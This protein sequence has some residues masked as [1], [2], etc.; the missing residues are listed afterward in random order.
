MNNKEK[1]KQNLKRLREIYENNPEISGILD[2][3]DVEEYNEVSNAWKIFSNPRIMNTINPENYVDILGSIIKEDTH[4]YKNICTLVKEVYGE[5]ARQIIQERPELSMDD[6][7]NFDIF[8][9]QIR[10]TIGYGG[11]HTFL[12]YYMSSEHIITEL[13]Q[14]P[15]LITY[16]KEFEKLTEGF[17][18]PS[19]IGLEDRLLAFEKHRG[20]IKS[21]VDS[22]KQNEYTN[23]LL[24]LLRD[25]EGFSM[26]TNISVAPD[27][28]LFDPQTDLRVDTLEQL[29]DYRRKREDVLQTYIEEVSD[30]P[31]AH[32][33]VVPIVLFK[34]FGIVKNSPGQYNAYD[35]K[36]FL[37]DYLQFNKTELTEDEIDLIEIYSILEEIEDLELLRKI[38]SFLS[39]R[40]DVVTPLRMK[41]IDNKVVENY[42]SEYVDSLVK[43]EQ[44]RQMAEDPES[45][46]YRYICKKNGDICYP[47]HM[48]CSSDNSQKYKNYIVRDG[49]KVYEYVGKNGEKITKREEKDTTVY[50][51]ENMLMVPSDGTSLYR[52]SL[53]ITMKNGELEEYFWPTH[54]N[55]EKYGLRKK[56]SYENQDG[57]LQRYVNTYTTPSPSQDDYYFVHK[58]PEGI[59]GWKR[60]KCNTNNQSV[61]ETKLYW[62]KGG[63]D[64]QFIQTVMEWRDTIEEYLGNLVQ[65][66]EK[67]HEEN[68]EEP[69]YQLIPQYDTNEVELEEGD[70]EGFVL[71]GVKAGQL[72]ISMQRGGPTSEQL[73]NNK[74]FRDNLK[75][76]WHG[77]YGFYRRCTSKNLY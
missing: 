27:E 77:R 45:K 15:E 59:Q 18:P 37:E 44:A 63:E 39:T 16:Y 72:C 38:D 33:L 35:H 2:S 60:I 58:M 47:T 13:A 65:D 66:I 22:E 8:D 3:I 67:A 61:E 6:I 56:V 5:N 31:Y 10:E 53:S 49:V 50:E 1:H 7:P 51:M 9:E 70:V 68:E 36:K 43:L 42:K 25:E 11:V 24:L 74:L 71:Y 34:H 57:K 46:S 29:L 4:A 12:T 48:Y 19:A 21:I 17:F 69:Y 73:A 26:L 75:R 28:Y 23:D 14:N 30:K 64:R 41:D 55:S 76:E 40:D 62:S 32:H 54:E 20:L 52:K